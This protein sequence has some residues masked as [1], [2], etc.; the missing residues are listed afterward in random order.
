MPPP[1]TTASIITTK[2]SDHDLIDKCITT[3]LGNK[4]HVYSLNLLTRQCVTFRQAHHTEAV[5]VRLN[6]PLAWYL[7]HPAKNIV[8]EQLQK[9]GKSLRQ[10]Q[11]LAVS[12]KR[13]LELIDLVSDKPTHELPSITKLY[14]ETEQEFTAR[15]Y[16]LGL[17]LGD[18]IHTAS[19]REEIVICA[20]QELQ[21]GHNPFQAFMTGIN[22]NQ[23]HYIKCSQFTA[24]ETDTCIPV[25]LY[26]CK[27]LEPLDL[28]K[29]VKYRIKI[30]AFKREFSALIR[31]GHSS[32][33]I[34]QLLIVGFQHVV[35]KR[36][37]LATS[38]HGDFV[39]FNQPCHT[40]SKLMTKIAT[41]AEKYGIVIAGD[42]NHKINDVVTM[43]SLAQSITASGHG[44]AALQS[45]LIGL[46]LYDTLDAIV[47]P[48]TFPKYLLKTTSLTVSLRF[49]ENYPLKLPLLLV[50]Q[51]REGNIE[52]FKKHVIE[53]YKLLQNLD[54]NNSTL[55]MHAVTGGQI[56][57]I[58]TLLE[59]PG[60]IT[61][62]N[63]C[64]K[65][66][67]TA[68]ILAAIEFTLYNAG[69][70]SGAI[71][72]DKMSKIKEIIELLYQYGA[73]PFQC[74]FKGESAASI[75]LAIPVAPIVASIIDVD[76][77]RVFSLHNLTV[78][79]M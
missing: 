33:N 32:D 21:N 68:L 7:E 76:W 41:L 13:Q 50:Q 66:G 10:I 62:I 53:N 46:Q 52:Y 40:T 59:Y 36:V 58:K 70:S 65:D 34:G 28:A 9:E 29:N 42:F 78:S 17:L 55:L 45:T 25:I 74:N 14:L 48:Y 77:D 47:V 72:H 16:R 31:E 3:K 12:G 35:S 4:L 54:W 56:T 63:H 51:V 11:E 67:N 27:Q 57:M 8:L 22:A 71:I 60:I 43:H 49:L 79:V 5:I 37:I 2:H 19:E 75:L 23:R 24:R 44:A 64:N 15:M 18:T 61:M 30:D 38:L 6:C 20:I 39:M 73:D 26:N 69:H 1:L